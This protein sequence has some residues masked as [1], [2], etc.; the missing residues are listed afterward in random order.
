[1]DKSYLLTI[2]QSTSGTKALLVDRAGRIVAQRTAEH[3]Q[4]APFPG[5]VEHDPVE[6]YANVLQTARSVMEE[7]AARPEQLAAVTLTNQRETA[8]LWDRVTGLPVYPAIVWQCRRTAEICRKLKA[9]GHEGEVR[10]K[11][12]LLLDPYFSA[13][14]WGWMLAEVPEAGQKLSEGRLLAGTIDSWLLWK[15]SGGRVHA[16]DVTNASRTSLYDIHK[17]QW[18]AELC[19]LFGVPLEILP[20]VKA[21]DVIY[22]YTDEPQLFDVPV[23]I[24]GIIGD[25]QGALLGQ[26]C[27]ETGT[28]KAT[29]GTG[30][31]VLLNAGEQPPE[32]GGG[33]VLT[34]AW[35]LGGSVTYALEAVIRTSGDCIKW[36]RDNLGLFGSFGEL[37][38]WL[39]EAPDSEG[40][41]LVPAFVGLGA[42]YW[43]P[44][45]RAAVTGMSRG[46]GR[47]HIIRAALESMAYQVRDAA[48]LIAAQTGIELKGLHAD[49]G[50]SA[51]E[52][53]MR[54]QADLLGRP[55]WRS[56]A[57]ELSAMGSAYAGGLAAGLWTSLGEI[58]GLE[59]T[60]QV[61]EPKLDALER[62]RKYRGWRRA[63]AAVLHSSHAEQA[64]EA[65]AE[66][67]AAALQNAVPGAAGTEPPVQKGLG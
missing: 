28:A 31:S 9:A 46:T 64:E 61:F 57:A 36:V 22:G 32:A 10:A 38:R 8:V 15:L 43:E 5:W 50:A 53:L 24:A 23:P 17:L 4:Y 2:D 29:Y 60:G 21:S 25:S 45:A 7:A 11:T 13:S 44:Q 59:R 30:T 56:S 41:Y 66:A 18:D 55:V 14:K 27:L 52:A 51:N 20:E 37:E 12:G 35:G 6:I 49:G 42:P 16:T 3:R 26:C 58:A 1:M 63:V 47:A 62:E 39:A 40:V 34:I 67:C 33:L 65:A 54:F 19:A 48:E